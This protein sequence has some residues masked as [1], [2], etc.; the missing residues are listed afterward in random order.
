[1][2]FNV[3]YFFVVGNYPPFIVSVKTFAWETFSN[4]HVVISEDALLY[5]MVSFNHNMVALCFKQ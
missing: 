3:K 1:M 5:F 4:G 2:I